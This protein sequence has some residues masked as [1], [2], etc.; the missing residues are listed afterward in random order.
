[1]ASPPP[2]AGQY[3]D[4]NQYAYAQQQQ[5]AYGQQPDQYGQAPQPGYPQQQPGFS[6]PPG[7]AAAQQPPVGSVSH[8]G[9]GKRRGYA[10]Q[11]YDFG[12]GAN[13]GLATGTVGSGVPMQAGY[14]EAQMGGYPQDPSVAQGQF[15]SPMGGAP[16]PV[17]GGVPPPVAPYGDAGVAGLSQQFGQMGMG[18]APQPGVA[19]QPQGLQGARALNQ[20]YPVDLMQQPFSVTELDLPPPEIVLPPNVCA[21]YMLAFLFGRAQKKL[22]FSS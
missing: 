17:Y 1:M 21:H 18:G 8:H 2:N 20:L 7:T 10:E 9:K 15:V 6:S 3:V 19:P 13:A 5:P 14:P 22:T 16:A 11:S 12:Q 4:P